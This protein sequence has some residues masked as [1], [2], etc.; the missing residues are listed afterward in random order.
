MCWACDDRHAAFGREREKTIPCGLDQ[1][2]AG[3]VDIQEELGMVFAGERPETG[4]SPASRNDD[5]E[6]L[7]FTVRER[8]GGEGVVAERGGDVNG[9]RDRNC[10][11]GRRGEERRLGAKTW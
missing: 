7:E 9:W 1:A 3:Q 10:C 2:A 6:T 8:K 5:V 11:D 4:A